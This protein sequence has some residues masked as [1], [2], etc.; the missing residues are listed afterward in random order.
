VACFAVPFIVLWAWI[1]GSQM[2]FISVI[3]PARLLNWT[4]EHEYHIE[5]KSAPVL[6][7]G[8]YLWTA[9]PFRRIYRVAVQ[10]R[11]GHLLSGWVRLGKTMWPCMSVEACPVEVRWDS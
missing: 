10:D 11:D 3:A 7:R 6:P 8:P 4:K 9:G 5:E 2:W 1:F